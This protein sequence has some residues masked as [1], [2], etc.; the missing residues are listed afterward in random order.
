MAMA[1]D[2]K[3]ALE[4]GQLMLIHPANLFEDEPLRR[5]LLTG[6]IEA[7]DPHGVRL[8][9]FTSDVDSFQDY[10]SFVPWASRAMGLGGTGDGGHAGAAAADAPGAERRHPPGAERGGGGGGRAR[11]AR[12]RKALSP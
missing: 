3:L 2:H 12:R 9:P 4:P 5:H 11:A 10:D 6:R 8:R 1:N 7:V